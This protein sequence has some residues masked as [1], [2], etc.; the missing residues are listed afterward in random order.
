MND[1][2]QKRIERIYQRALDIDGDE[3]AAFLS[4]ECGDDR[5]LRGEVETL[6]SHYEAA[7]DSFLRSPLSDD[8]DAPERI[9]TYDVKRTL[10]EGGMG[11]VYLAEQIEPIRRNVAIKLIKP[12]LDTKSVI[13][14]FHAERQALALLNHPN[15]ARVFDADATSD[16]RPYFVMEYIE[17][18]TLVEFCDAERLT[19]Q[20]R[21]RLFLQICDGVQYAHQKGIIHRDLKPSNI[22]VT[23]TDGKPVPKII[24]F[25]I[26]KA[27]ETKLTEETLM[28]RQ[29]DIIGTPEYMSPEQA[30]RRDDVDT[31][32]DVYSLGVVLYELLAG[33]LPFTRA[34]LREA[35][36]ASMLRHIREVSPPR[37]STRVNDAGPKSDMTAGRRSVDSRTLAR[38]LAGDLDWITMKALEKEP[39]R[40]YGTPGSFAEDLYRYLN[41]EPVTARAPSRAYRTRMF[42]RRN[43]V[44]VSFAALVLVASVAFAVAMGVQARRVAVERDRANQEAESLREVSDFIVGLFE[45]ADPSQARGDTVTVREVIDRG[46]ET[47]RD[48]SELDPLIHARMM[49]VLGRVYRNLGIYSEADSLLTGALASMRDHGA[50]PRS[51]IAALSDLGYK[52]QIVSDYETAHVHFVEALTIA[53]AHL[54]PD[55]PDLIAVR[56]QIGTNHMRLGEYELALAAHQGTLGILEQSGQDATVL[57]GNVLNNLGLTYM[58]LGKVGTATE[59]FERALALY[60]ALL[61]DDH[62]R[63]AGTLGNL[64]DAYRQLNELEKALEVQE[65]AA[66]LAIRV[67]GENSRLAGTQLNMLGVIHRDME[68]YDEAIVYLERAQ[69]AWTNSLGPDHPYLYYPLQSMGHINKAVGRDSLA[70][71]LYEEALGLRLRALGPDHSH[72]TYAEANVGTMKLAMGDPVGAEPHLRR[73]V[74]IAEATLPPLHTRSVLGPMDLGE[75]LMTLDR[76]DEAEKL[77]VEVHERIWQED[78]AVSRKRRS[79]D[80]LVVLYEETNRAQRAQ[81]VR[82]RLAALPAEE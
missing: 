15:I 11:A 55:D 45:A 44:G 58:N 57:M 66:G 24:D 27:T 74:E 3:R 13:A 5:E 40:R 9:G 6:L 16:G 67:H 18:A 35:G 62:P 17:G 2:R 1:E 56:V 23:L 63:L 34:E 82:A 4:K 50:Q 52:A 69:A 30:D 39:D 26:A 80:L 77:L 68:Q 10:G 25:G 65:R 48:D 36:E 31:R 54:A 20:E 78:V 61:P 79:A 72:I 28:T 19:V 22:I 42:V 46:V 64:A 70:L 60:E 53:E 37:P 73:S 51:V 43:R 12:G 14:R 59:Y 76:Y 7:P 47:L 41:H 21:I 29:G 8:V 32:T 81:D 49:H 75:C 71:A 33:A 38:L